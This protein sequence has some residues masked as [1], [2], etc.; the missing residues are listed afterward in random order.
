MPHPAPG[1]GGGGWESRHR[2]ILTPPR[3]PSPPE[4]KKE[5]KGIRVAKI[6]GDAGAFATV[7]EFSPR[8]GQRGEG[9]AQ[10]PPTDTP[11][12]FAL[13]DGWVRV[14]W[15]GK[16]LPAHAPLAQKVMG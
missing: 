15:Q 1:A 5:K 13:N 12:A 14:F 7:P 9:V 11:G 4:K 3:T 2:V 6:E 16:M 10:D 8:G